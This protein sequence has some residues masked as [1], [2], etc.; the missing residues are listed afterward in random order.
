M[1][2]GFEW[3]GIRVLDAFRGG[4]KMIL[5]MILVFNYLF[6]FIIKYDVL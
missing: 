2:T 4:N 1:Q 6:I 3:M 5:K